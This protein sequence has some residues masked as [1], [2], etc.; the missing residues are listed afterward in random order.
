[1][2]E[3]LISIGVGIILFIILREFFCWY[4]KINAMQ[5][6]MEEQRDLLKYLVKKLVAKEAKGNSKI[7]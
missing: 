1:M 3:I 4:W 7:S 5:K 6:I 2:E